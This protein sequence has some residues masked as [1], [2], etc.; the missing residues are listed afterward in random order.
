MAARK[1]TMR[2]SSLTMPSAQTITRPL[3]TAEGVLGLMRMMGQSTPAISRIVAMVSPAAID[4]ST[5]GFSLPARA[6]WMSASMSAIM[7]GFTPRNRKSL[8]RA[9][10][11][12][13]QARAPRVPASAA[14]FSGVR[15]A[16][17]MCSPP[18][19]RLTAVASAPPML[20]QPIKPKISFDMWYSSRIALSA[21]G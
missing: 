21:K 8:S 2:G 7:K 1:A 10:L 16:S 14:A 3:P 13:S 9:A 5:Q 11:T 12:L 19:M 15:L 6:S 4:T 18:T 20:P 17:N